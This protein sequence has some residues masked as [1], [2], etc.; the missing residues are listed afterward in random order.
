MDS[1]KFTRSAAD[2]EATADIM[3]W[4]H[5]SNLELVAHLGEDEGKANDYEEPVSIRGSYK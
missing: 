4:E 1:L 3:Q 2:T 5:G